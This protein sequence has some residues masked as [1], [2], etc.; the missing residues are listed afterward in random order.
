MA[1]NSRIYIT[2]HAQAEHNVDLDYTILDA[3]LT[4]LGKKQAASLAPRIPDL[5]KKADLIVTSPLQRTLQ[6][7]LLGWGPAVKRLGIK[8]VV[9]LPAAQECNDF[10]CD[11]GLPREQLEQNPEFKGF[12]FSRLT[13]DWTSKTGFWAPD[14][15]SIANRARAVRHFLRERP[16]KNIVLVGHGDII[17]AVTC[18]A[19]GPST[20]MWK[21]TETQVYRFDP[22][23][24]E[25]DECYLALEEKIEAAG[26]YAP[27]STEMDIDG[28]IEP[29]GELDGEPHGKI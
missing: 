14:D 5:Q 12:D 23:T 28:A 2:R 29:N 9:C 10:P 11:T 4:P 3:P 27:T 20:Y 6:T 19:N 8:N 26:G 18:D 1:P 15:R 16:E 7:T 22:E 17:R 13:P 24:V 21:N 25:D